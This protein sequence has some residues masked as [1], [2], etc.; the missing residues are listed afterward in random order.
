MSS[1]LPVPKKPGKVQLN[2]WVAESTNEALTEMAKKYHLRGRTQ[3]A[4]VVIEKYLPKWIEQQEKVSAEE[5]PPTAMGG[6]EMPRD[7]PDD[8]DENVSGHRRIVP[9][10]DA[11]PRTKKKGARTARNV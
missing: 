11:T 10:T 3:V 7:I 6:V 2:L 8:E 1:I 5:A 9:L 4:E